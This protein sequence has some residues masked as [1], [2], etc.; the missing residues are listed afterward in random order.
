YTE[1]FGLPETYIFLLS[2]VVRLGHFKDEAIGRS[3]AIGLKEYLS[4]A[5]SVEQCIQRLKK[6]PEIVA[7]GPA[8]DPE[9]RG[10]QPI[11]E[12]LAT[13]ML[14]ALTIYSYRRVYDV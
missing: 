9:K 2:L 5:K 14:Q 10:C 1:I 4:R 13:A 11:L 3:G 6:R 12:T 7:D 8:A